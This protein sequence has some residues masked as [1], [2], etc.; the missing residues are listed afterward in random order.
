MS[1]L[2]DKTNAQKA[3]ARTFA[4]KV[5]R[6]RYLHAAISF[7][8]VVL[9]PTVGS[10]VYLNTVAA[11]QYAT[12]FRF[13]VRGRQDGGG[14]DTLGLMLGAGG[15]IA[16]SSDS[17]IIVDYMESLEMIHALN[18]RLDLHRIYTAEPGDIFHSYSGSPATEDLLDYWKWMI[19]AEFDLSRGIIA[20]QIWSF[21]QE[22]SLAISREVLSL[23]GELVN[24][25]SREAREEALQYAD[26]QVESAGDK[27]R[28][29]R[30]AIQDFRK[31][32][33]V[34]DPTADAVRLNEQIGLLE[35]ALI[36]LTTELETQV[37]TKGENSASAE[38]LRERIDSTQRQLAAVEDSIDERL[39]ELARVYEAL[40][41][42]VE[43][44]RETYAA[45]LRARLE[46]EAIAT[47]RQVYLS[48]YDTPKLAQTSL[49]PNRAVLSAVILVL[50]F[51]IW[52]I[53]YVVMLNIRDAAM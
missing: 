47:Q 1:T 46:A 22:D 17:Y 5:R 6:R 13:A 50:S 3:Q 42:D 19:N 4:K 34:I 18:E 25:I 44:A 14:A 26:E 29:A 48:V 38:Q 40:Q 45:A 20:A 7:A 36:E 2:K 32:E 10:Y 30:V 53:V 12:E 28:D 27:L 31:R 24:Q 33:N 51:V 43:I 15:A 21:S 41:T 39:P 35:R 52:G 8:I 49:Y 23:T 37:A 9:A 11:N 16:T